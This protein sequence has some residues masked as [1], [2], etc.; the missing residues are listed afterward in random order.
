METTTKRS[1][2]EQF[3]FPPKASLINLHTPNA[4]EVSYT[5]RVISMQVVDI[6]LPMTKS[7]VYEYKTESKVTQAVLLRSVWIRPLEPIDLPLRVQVLVDQE[8][9]LDQPWK[10][11]LAGGSSSPSP[12]ICNDW[13]EE[14]TCS[15][16]VTPLT[17]FRPKAALMW[18]GKMTEEGVADANSPLGVFAPRQSLVQIK[19]VGVSKTPCRFQA[20]AGITAALYSSDPKDV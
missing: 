16:T 12:C 5:H 8:I 17:P 10:D 20:R 18:A 7:V 2:E 3:D 11:H 13:D 14:K 1:A 6:E 15:C 19:L 9:V 4:W